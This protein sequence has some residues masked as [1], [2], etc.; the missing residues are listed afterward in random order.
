MTSTSTSTSTLTAPM[1]A[2]AAAATLLAKLAHAEKIVA[3]I[4]LLAAELALAPEAMLPEIP[5]NTNENKIDGPRA[6][7][8]IVGGSWN[9]RSNT[10]ER[11]GAGGMRLRVEGSVNG[12]DFAGWVEIENNWV[13]DA[14]RNPNGRKIT[15][16]ADLTRPDRKV[17]SDAARFKVANLVADHVAEFVTP[18][19]LDR[20][21]VI[22]TAIN[23]TRSFVNAL[24]TYGHSSDAKTA[25]AKMV[26]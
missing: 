2:A 16:I 1:D 23:K 7:V 13:Y 5:F 3:D 19:D 21:G 15:G 4:D 10:N 18:A 26:R 6:T 8:L 25:I 20:I 17:V 22:K 24:K 14:D 12:N 11:L 9:T